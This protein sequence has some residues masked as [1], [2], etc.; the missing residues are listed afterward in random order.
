MTQ[1]TMPLF[2]VSH[3][4]RESESSSRKRNHDE[5]SAEAGKVDSAEDVKNVPPVSIQEPEDDCEY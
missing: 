1:L 4:V 5:F 3:N 2:E